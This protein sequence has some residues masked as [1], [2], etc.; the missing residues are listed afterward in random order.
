VEAVDGVEELGGRGVNVVLGRLVV[1]KVRGEVK[2]ERGATVRTLV[3]GRDDGGARAGIDV[4]AAGVGE[5]GNGLETKKKQRK[6]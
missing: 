2:V 1:G 3:V 5:P 6:R 4:V